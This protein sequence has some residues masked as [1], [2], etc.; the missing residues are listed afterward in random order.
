MGLTLELLREPPVKPW[1]PAP[2]TVL[3]RQAP[4]DEGESERPHS[5]L[6]EVTVFLICSLHYTI[7]GFNFFFT[8]ENTKTVSVR[9]TEL[10]AFY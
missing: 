8:T 9:Q 3:Y 7:L 2:L 1:L 5:A 10:C 6:L 4:G